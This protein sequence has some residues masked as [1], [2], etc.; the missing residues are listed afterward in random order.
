MTFIMI[1]SNF[2][3]LQQ[4]ICSCYLE[5]ISSSLPVEVYQVCW[6][7][8][9]KKQSICLAASSGWDSGGKARSIQPQTTKAVTKTEGVT[10]TRTGNMYNNLWAKS[11]FMLSSAFYVKG[12]VLLVTSFVT[13]W[14]WIRSQFV[15]CMNPYP[16]YITWCEICH[17]SNNILWGK[18]LTSNYK[19]A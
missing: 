3:I 17:Y 12:V 18:K 15:F 14:W 4:L 7:S 8:Y 16:Q 10:L 9:L 6:D 11:V 2:D 5:H 19:K 13:L 1:H